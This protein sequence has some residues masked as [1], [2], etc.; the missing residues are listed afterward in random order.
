MIDTSQAIKSFCK[1]VSVT[2]SNP[3]GTE[4]SKIE[5][6]DTQ[7][8]TK[9]K[10]NYAEVACLG[11]ASGVVHLVPSS[12]TYA[13][14]Q[15]SNPVA[16]VDSDGAG[17]VLCTVGQY[18]PSPQVIRTSGLEFF[19]VIQVENRTTADVEVVINYGVVYTANPLDTLKVPSRGL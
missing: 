10:C 19:D 7:G 1:V 8:D 12:T 17:G 3:F 16:G 2:P 6:K 5:L 9:I 4:L 15:V 13:Y 11:N 14:D 18:S